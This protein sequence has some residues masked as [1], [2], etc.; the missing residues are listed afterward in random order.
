[1]RTPVAFLATLALF[2]GTAR[3]LS[4]QVVISE[5]NFTPQQQGDDQWIEI[6]NLGSTKVDLTTWSIYQ[7]TATP[8]RPQNYWFGFPAGVELQPGAYLR[9]H[10][11]APIKPGA[12]LP[13][14]YTGDTVYHF[15]F[16]LKAEPLSPSAGALALMNTQQNIRMN[17]PKAIQDWVSWGKSGL[18]RESLAV[19]GGRWLRGQ[20]VQSPVQK[21]SLALIYSRNAEPTPASAFFRDSSPTPLAH[22]HPSAATASYGTPCSVGVVAPPVLRDLSIPAPGNRDFGL[23]VT[24]TTSGHQVLLAFSPGRGTGSIKFGPCILRISPAPPTFVAIRSSAIG[25]TDLLFPIPTGVAGGRAF[26]QALVL[27][28]PSDFGFTNGIQLDLGI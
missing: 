15:L 25:R 13:E 4:S 23:R 12:K 5:I 11:L 3:D 9:V 7:A 8:N 14:L 2:A 6:L 1:M 18:K 28:S 24:P 20:F 27:A 22:N 17:D 21:D 19:N 16:G 10:W 26:V